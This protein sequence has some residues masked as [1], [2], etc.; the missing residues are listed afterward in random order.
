MIGNYNPGTHQ[1]QENFHRKTRGLPEDKRYSVLQK[2]APALNKLLKGMK[3]SLG[4]IDTHTHISYNDDGSVKKTINLITQ[5]QL[6]SLEHLKR[7][8][9]VL[10]LRWPGN[11]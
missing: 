10:A 6:A 7:Q 4:G 8:A 3:T 11:G 2:K 5:H 9:Q 1:G